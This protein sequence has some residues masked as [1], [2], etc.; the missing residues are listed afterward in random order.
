M[1]PETAVQAGFGEQVQPKTDDKNRLWRE[2][3][4]LGCRHWFGDEYIVEGR[5]RLKCPRSHCGKITI[6]EFR[7]RKPEKGRTPQPNGG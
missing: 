6:M 3:R 4:C 1:K 5:I 7:K 2:L